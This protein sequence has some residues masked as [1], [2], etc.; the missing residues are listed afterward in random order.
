MAVH[1][2]VVE[3]VELVD[4]VMFEGVLALLVVALFD[5]FYLLLEVDCFEF[6]I[7]VLGV[8]LAR[9]CAVLP[10]LLLKALVRVLLELQKLLRGIDGFD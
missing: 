10:I 4:V 2:G 3:G 5:L 7:Q 8:G 6:F 9:I 1:A